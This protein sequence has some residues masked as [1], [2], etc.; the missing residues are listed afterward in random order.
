MTVIYRTAGP[1]GAGKGANL[2]AG[3]VDGNFY[4][5]NVR[6]GSVEVALPTL[7][8]IAFFEVAGPQFYVHLTNGVI[9]GPFALPATT[10]NFR[11]EW[12]PFT[13]YAV[14]DIVSAD[15]GGVYMVLAIHNSAAS[16][17]PGAT[18][19]SGG[20]S[21]GIAFYGLLL[22]LQSVLP[23]GGAA[24]TVLSKLTTNDYDVVWRQFGELPPG[25]TTGQ[26]ARKHSGADADVEWATVVLDDLG[27][28]TLT[29]PANLDYLRFDAT[30]N[31]WVNQQP[32]M[33]KVTQ[34]SSY[35]PALSDMGAF[36]IITNGPSDAMITVPTNA[37]VAFP[38]GA[39]LTLH[40]DGTGTVTISPD[41]G[42]T[43]L[44]HATFQNV[45][46]GQYATA[47]IK[48]TNTDEWRLFGLLVQ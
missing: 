47:T 21:G 25:G 42:V 10:W 12:Q 41:T 35:S 44:Y 45:L 19:A 39:E 1:W 17:D 9:Q 20:L 27:G 15:D 16:F 31:A 2:H 40:Q 37:S 33:L 6:L 26:L 48:K 46:L 28:V 23:A 14:N 29:S 32:T 8:S 30:L 43:L 4:D 34:S 18:D 7:A 5:I 13:L 38:I 22:M 36:V 11:G 24:N 3:E